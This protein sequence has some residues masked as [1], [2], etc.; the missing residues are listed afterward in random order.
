MNNKQPLSQKRKIFN[1]LYKE[2]KD[3]LKPLDNVEIKAYAAHFYQ[4]FD[5]H[6]KY[7][8]DGTYDEFWKIFRALKEGKISGVPKH[9]DLGNYGLDLI[10]KLLYEEIDELELIENVICFRNLADY[11]GENYLKGTDKGYEQENDMIELIK[12]RK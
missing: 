5:L 8:N 6:R 3:K 4:Y 11:L 12:K 10:S 9:E 2:V 1:K 7:I